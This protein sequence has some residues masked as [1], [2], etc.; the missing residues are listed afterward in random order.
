MQTTSIE[1]YRNI[2][3]EPQQKVK[4]FNY[5]E[6]HGASTIRMVAHALDMEISTVSARINSL[7]HCTNPKLEQAFKSKDPITG[8]RSIF[9]RPVREYEQSKLFEDTF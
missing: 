6:E 9:W 3:F 8:V 7:V 4:I 1:A 5:I 2:K